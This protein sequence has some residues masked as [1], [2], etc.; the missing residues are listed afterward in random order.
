METQHGFMVASKMSLKGTER[1]VVEN[2]PLHLGRV[3]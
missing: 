1:I 2:R 3:C